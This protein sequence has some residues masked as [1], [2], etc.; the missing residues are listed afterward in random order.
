MGAARELTPSALA[1]RVSTP[2]PYRTLADSQGSY[3]ECF[4]AVAVLPPY[5]ERQS[6]R[7]TGALK[8][9]HSTRIRESASIAATVTRE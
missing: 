6:R 1:C 4:V 3:A 5:D 7:V 9:F 8:I 2:D